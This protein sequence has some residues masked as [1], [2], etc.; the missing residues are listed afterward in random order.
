[1]KAVDARSGLEILDRSACLRL[2][3]AD[4]IGRLAVIAGGAPVILP[5]N[6]ALDGE[7]IVFRT[8]EGTKSRAA[9]RAPA[10][11]EIDGF[12]RDRRAGWSVV[13]SGRLE[14]VT[15]YD[16]ATMDRVHALPVDP[17]AGGEKGHWMRL[18]PTHMTGRCVGA[19]P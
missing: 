19:S 11:F 5:V 14:E 8:D 18:V 16:A 15:P 4:Q 3:A 7:A 10:C 6:Y 2:L 17:W 13:V 9:G 12:D 1:M